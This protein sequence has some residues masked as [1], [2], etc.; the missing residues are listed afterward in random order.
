M[1]VDLPLHWLAILHYTFASPNY[2]LLNSAV[3]KLH[4][5][6]QHFTLQL[7]YISFLFDPIGFFFIIFS[8]LLLCFIFCFFIHFV[9]NFSY[10]SHYF[11]IFHNWYFFRDN[12]KNRAVPYDTLHRPAF[13]TLNYANPYKAFAGLN[14]ISHYPCLA[15]R[16]ITMHYR[17][18]AARH[19][20]ILYLCFA[21]QYVTVRRHAWT[22][23]YLTI[24]SLCSTK[25]NSTLPFLCYTRHNL[26]LPCLSRAR[27]EIP[28]ITYARLH[29]TVPYNTKP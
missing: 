12:K 1:N 6:K 2:S 28:C 14:Y 7:R 8:N 10:E 15:A 9:T 19:I 11:E 16:Y 27:L 21:G 17:C 29:I 3:A 20:A 23:L 5:A 13:A 22:A 26:T 4:I 24:P 25:R 18:P